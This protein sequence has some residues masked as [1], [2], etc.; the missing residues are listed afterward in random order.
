MGK[1]YKL[2]NE[3]FV[4]IHRKNNDNDFDYFRLDVDIKLNDKQFI[5]FIIENTVIFV[6]NDKISYVALYNIDRL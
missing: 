6:Q 1:V 3:I 2:E 5:D 4:L